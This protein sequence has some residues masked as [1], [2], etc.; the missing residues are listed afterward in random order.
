MK[1]QKKGNKKF[2]YQKKC[3]IEKIPIKL[4]IINK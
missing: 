4:K 3:K 1:G 2:I